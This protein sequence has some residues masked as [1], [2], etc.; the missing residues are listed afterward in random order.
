[1][2]AHS[3]KEK[4]DQNVILKLNKIKLKMASWVVLKNTYKL[5]IIY[6]CW[7]FSS[8]YSKKVFTLF[9]NEQTSS[10]FC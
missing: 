1:M 6:Y 4:N 5:N 3:G 2:F 7:S 10:S 9:Q 8:F